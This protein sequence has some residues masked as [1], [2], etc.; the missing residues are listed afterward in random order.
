M[1]VVLKSRNY[2]VTKEK[3]AQENDYSCSVP[4]LITFYPINNPLLSIVTWGSGLA[5]SFLTFTQITQLLLFSFFDKE[6]KGSW[7]NR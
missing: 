1:S 3:M 4:S 7:G 6:E 2:Q 5:G